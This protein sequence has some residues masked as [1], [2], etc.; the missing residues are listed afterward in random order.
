MCCP[1]AAVRE[2]LFPRCELLLGRQPPPSRRDGP[3]WG[4]SRDRGSQETGAA[5]VTSCGETM[6]WV[7]SNAPLGSG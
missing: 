7:S 3:Q 4:G 2:D 1:D 5:L 6:T